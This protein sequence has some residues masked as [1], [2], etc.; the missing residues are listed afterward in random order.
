VGALALLSFVSTT[1]LGGAWALIVRTDVVTDLFPLL[2][3]STLSRVWRDPALLKLGLQFSIPTLFILLCHELGHWFACRRHALAASPPYFLPAPI[4]L[5]TFGAF[6]RI[7]SPVR[8]KAELL[9]VGIS[10]PIA[11][12]VALL[13]VLAAG[14][15]LSTAGRLDTAAL[16]GMTLLLYRPGESLLTSALVHIFH[17]SLPAGLLLNPHPF[18]L[19]GWVGL[20]ATMLNLLPLAQL[21]GGHILYA[22]AGRV[23]RRLALVFW[24]ALALLGFLWPGWWLWCAVLLVLGLRHPRVVDESLPLD[25]RRRR[26]AAAALGIL[27]LTFMPV[28]IDVLTIAPA[29]PAPTSLAARGQVEHESHRARVHQLDLHAG[30]EAPALHPGA[31]LDERGRQAIAEG[32]GRFGGR[33]AVERRPPSTVERR[34]QRE[35]RHEQEGAASFR[36]RSVHPT[37]FVLEEAQFEQLPGRGRDF[38]F[39]VARLDAHQDDEPA[40]DRRDPFAVD[41]HVRARHSLQDEAHGIRL[42]RMTGARGAPAPAAMIAIRREERSPC[43]TESF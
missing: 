38:G 26:F 4:G 43:S 14:V 17:G 24:I 21:D 19:A 29:S 12:F 37:A 35:L 7:H 10:G 3:P 34:E 39:G 36:E 28:P 8:T 40:T 30:A 33:G 31:P 20:F 9:D 18:L 1:T 15:A 11:G 27:V 32:A 16:P 2:T 41:L 25:A 42:L 23:H 5:G 22:V 13:P 6:I